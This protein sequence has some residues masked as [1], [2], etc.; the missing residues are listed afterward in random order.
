MIRS[1]LQIGER[2]KAISHG[3]SIIEVELREIEVRPKTEGRKEG[4]VF[5]CVN[6]MTQKLIV[7]NAPN[8][9]TAR[10]KDAIGS[11][12]QDCQKPKSKDR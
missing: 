11:E 10:A 2:Y 12:L 3:G 4:E 8:K 5:I 9:F 6:V 7:L 1:E